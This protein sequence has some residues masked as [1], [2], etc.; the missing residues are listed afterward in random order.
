MNSVTLENTV[1]IVVITY[2]GG[3]ANDVAPVEVRI[4]HRLSVYQRGS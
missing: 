4:F 1:G 2:M 3:L